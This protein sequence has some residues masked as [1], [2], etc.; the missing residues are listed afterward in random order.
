MRVTRATI[1]CGV[2]RTVSLIEFVIGDFLQDRSYHI[3][4]RFSERAAV[5]WAV[6]GVPVLASSSSAAVRWTGGGDWASGI[7]MVYQVLPIDQCSQNR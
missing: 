3:K 1:S 4:M 2:L 7:E 6:A 5:N